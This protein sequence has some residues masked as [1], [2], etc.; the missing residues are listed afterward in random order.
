VTLQQYLT[1]RTAAELAESIEQ[2]IRDG[3]L[4]AGDTLPPIRHLAEWL[5]LSAGTV[6]SA[7]RVLNTRGLTSSDRRRG[8]WVRE[9]RKGDLAPVRQAM[10]VP[11]GVTDCSSGNP[12]P[13]L[14]PDPIAALAGLSYEPA[15]YGSTV[16]HPGFLAEARRRLGDDGVPSEHATVSFGALD[17]ISRVLVSNLAP[18]DR[19]ALEDPG[20]AALIDLV[21][22][23]GYLPV[24]LPVDPEGPTVEGV[25]HELAAGAQAAVV[26]A[27]AQNPTGAAISAQR[28]DDLRAVF[29]RYP[30][31][32]VIEDDHACGL[33]ELPL[34][35]VAG[36]TGRYA[37]VRSLAKGYGADL[38][39]A[40]VAGDATTIG[41]LESSIVTGAGWVSHLVQQIALALW[42]DPR[43]AAQLAEASATYRD[44]RSALCTELASHGIDVTSPTGLNVWVPVDDEAT[45]VGVLLAQ[46]WLVAPGGRFRIASPP[47]IRVTT[48]AL[49]T[50]RAAAC[51][52]AVAVACAASRSKGRRSGSGG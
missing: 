37:F 10:P 27:R 48:A 31:R 44:R 51:A 17:A 2:S 23:L 26:T 3:R 46:G 15:L 4:P 22:R 33:V 38:R 11:D 25:W 39:L 36:P 24:P 42:L 45:A 19:V 29:A 18:G 21:E 14:L 52:D 34:S 6:A 8:T 16:A 5:G 9:L 20:W 50:E 35:V 49:P 28:A 1:G 13:R 30:G 7:Y 41:R 12:D 43:V 32:L 40:V 47:A